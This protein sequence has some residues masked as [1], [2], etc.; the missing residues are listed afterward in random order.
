MANKSYSRSDVQVI[1]AERGPWHSSETD[2]Q[3]Y[4][5]DDHV[6]AGAHHHGDHEERL[7]DEANT[8]EALSNHGVTRLAS[9]KYVRY[10]TGRIQHNRH[11]QI[12]Q[13]RNYTCL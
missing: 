12:R 4:E 10:V 7:C 13:R 5:S 6:S 1:D 2:S 11:D 9:D 3:N 8:A